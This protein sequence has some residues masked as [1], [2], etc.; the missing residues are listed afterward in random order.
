MCNRPSHNSTGAGRTDGDERARDTRRGRARARRGRA[1]GWR[2][3][4]AA[5]QQR[6]QARL[7]SGHLGR[8][9]GAVCAEGAPQSVGL[10]GRVARVG[11]GRCGRRLGRGRQ[12][13]RR[14]LV[15]HGRYTSRGLCTFACAT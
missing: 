6:M 14:A 9:G 1:A 11:V 4:A 15:R 3:C 13:E 8:L 5:A 12:P 10:G 2:C 7:Q